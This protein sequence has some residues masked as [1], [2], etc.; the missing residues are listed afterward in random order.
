MVCVCVCVGG[1]GGGVGVERRELLLL[2]FVCYVCLCVFFVLFFCQTLRSTP[3][4]RLICAC[5]FFHWTFSLL[6]QCHNE[7]AD[8]CFALHVRELFSPAGSD[9][10]SSWSAGRL[11]RSVKSDCNFP[12]PAFR[13]CPDQSQ[14]P[15]I[16]AS[17]LD[18]RPT[19]RLCYDPA[20]TSW[21]LAVLSSPGTG[22]RVSSLQ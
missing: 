1:V 9:S 16:P 2:V 10:V 17:P 19:N 4:S 13:F 6:T 3:Q 8:P 21:S 7:F 12:R 20:L 5:L 14:P 11:T 22:H 18:H 15:S